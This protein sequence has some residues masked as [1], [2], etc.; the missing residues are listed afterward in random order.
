MKM[1]KATST[2]AL[3][4]AF[5][6]LL[7]M[8]VS[9]VCAASYTLTGYQEF[10]V[11][12][13]QKDE[14]TNI[15]NLTFDKSNDDKAITLIHF[16]VPMDHT[17]YFTLY[18]GTGNTVSGSAKTA[19][20]TSLL[21][22]QTTTSSITF[23]GETKEYSY[24]DTNPEYDY[25]LSGYA[26]SNENN[27][28]GLIVYNAGYGSFDNELAVFMPVSNIAANLIYKVDLSCDVPF[29]A[30][31]SYGTA[32]E[33]AQSVSK[34]VIDVAWD[35]I[36]LALALGGTLLGFV[37]MLIGLIKFFFVD[38][39]LLVIAL[40]LGVTMAYSAISTRN[41]FQFY[42]KFFRYQRA[43]L[44]F[45]VQLW[46]YLIQIISSFRGIFRI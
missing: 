33:V 35:W 32:S 7:G 3:L 37:L 15:L 14:A 36:N 24:L 27:E 23:N 29:D 18:Y 39:L 8:I 17:V 21:P 45:M 10:N 11:F 22:L 31:I 5:L 41:I 34:S 43:L 30:D 28:T 38:N 9:P 16:K 12:D 6:V 13:V 1:K 4:L 44:D 25:F 2:K 40:W 42:T 26:R 20:N 46:N 19:W